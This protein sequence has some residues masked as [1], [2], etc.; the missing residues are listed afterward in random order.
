MWYK[1]TNWGHEHLSKIDA[2]RKEDVFINTNGEIPKHRLS[3][4]D[5]AAGSRKT[6]DAAITEEWS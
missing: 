2:W 1:L 5:L 3:V 4:S 6:R